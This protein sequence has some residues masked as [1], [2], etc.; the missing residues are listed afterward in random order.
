MAPNGAILISMAGTLPIM[1]Y[2]DKYSPCTITNFWLVVWSFTVALAWI[3][4]NHYF[5]W[6]GFHMD[7]WMGCS[8]MGISLWIHLVARFRVPLTVL[9]LLALLLLMMLGVQYITGVVLQAGNAWVSAMYLMGFMLAWL[10]GAR[11]TIANKYQ[12]ADG[13]FLAIG[14]A[15]FISVGLQLHQW[16][17]L[18]RLD[19]WSM[20]GGDARPYANFGQPNQLGTLLIWGL[21]GLLWGVERRYIRPQAA[22]VGA[23]WLLF[24]IALTLSR[25]AWLGL[26]LLLF[27]TW[28]WRHHWTYKETP[29]IALTLAIYFIACIFFVRWVPHVLWGAS[30]QDW[31]N[32]SSIGSASRPKLWML[33]IDAVKQQPW[34]GYGWNQSGLAHL[35]MALK[36][37]PLHEY[38]NSAHNIFL[39][40]VLWC[41]L[42][43]GVVASVYLLWWMISRG[44]KVKTNQDIILWLLVLV[45]ANHAMLELPLH[46]AY[47]LMPVGL[48]MGGLDMRLKN[49]SLNSVGR[50]ATMGLW[51][52]VAVLLGLLIR[53][54]A[55]V[56]QTHLKL[57][58][59]LAGV[60]DVQVKPLEVLLLTQWRDYVEISLKD[61]NTLMSEEELEWMRQR[62]SLMPTPGLFQLLALG[63]VKRREFERAATTLDGMCSITAARVCDS[64][65]SFWIY[66]ATQDIDI[67]AVAWPR[68]NENNVQN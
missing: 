13:L 28:L 52:I 25:T 21:L 4:P 24:G 32:I 9:P 58:Y 10:T 31:A 38:F 11:W 61:P 29:W 62:V 18:D 57:R 36:H 15:A 49:H 64:V 56:E 48:V 7:A 2:I 19:V 51:L 40:L 8:L 47:F 35:T 45:V 55:R 23:V 34:W 68:K 30:N 27:I 54:Y 17:Q 44:I 66:R 39:D 12:F 22:S 33:F 46:Y 53:D 63:Y 16:L 6:S 59:K 67:A 42:P 41:G 50:G 60:Q 26:T 37:P 20:G 3:L 5:P 65:K 43:I 1:I 14:L